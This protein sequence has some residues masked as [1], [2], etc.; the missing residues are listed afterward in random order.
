MYGWTL[1]CVVEQQRVVPLG[2]PH[3][4]ALTARDV[5]DVAC[6]RARLDVDVPA[7]HARLLAGR[8]VV[9]ATLAAGLPTY[10]LNR[11]LG[12]LRDVE[13]PLELMADFQKFVILTHA[14]AI[15][16]S[17]SRVEARAAIVVRLA[18]LA[19]G[20]SG[21]STT[22]F[23]GLLDLLTHDVVPVIPS[24][25]SVGAADL[26]Q[27]AAIGLVLVGG[28]QAFL[29]GSDEIVPGAQALAAAGLA[30]ITLEPKDGLAVLT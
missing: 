26:S 20:G 10:G 11:G 27:L 9:D 2:G 28:G 8:R 13:I 30:P 5:A 29:P 15:G 1:P 12:P 17:L 3:G 19:A 25:G 7:V 23:D 18:N 4:S 21:V 14:A 24:E 22:L 16:D 6:G